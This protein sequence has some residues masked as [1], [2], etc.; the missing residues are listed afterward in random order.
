MLQGECLM[1]PAPTA[2]EAFVNTLLYP[3]GHRAFPLSFLHSDQH[4]TASSF[5]ST[6]VWSWRMWWGGVKH[7]VLQCS[8]LFSYSLVPLE[9]IPRA[10]DHNCI[11]ASPSFCPFLELGFSASHA[12]SPHLWGMA[13]LPSLRSTVVLRSGYSESSEH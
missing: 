3:R 4:N 5:L 7:L 1:H 11:P 8:Y 6:V 2:C 9:M 13:C 12:L 10:G